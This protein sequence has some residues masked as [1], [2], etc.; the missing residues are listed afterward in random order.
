M[1]RG[2][3]EKIQDNVVDGTIL[4]AFNFELN[5]DSSEKL[6][7]FYKINHQAHITR[8]DYRIIKS[9]K[10]KKL[11][12]QSYRNLKDKKSKLIKANSQE[13]LKVRSL[14]W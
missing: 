4:S 10:I 2:T 5:T 11:D 6:S 3:L 14:I 13:T 9:P 1:E 8:F 12:S 7:L